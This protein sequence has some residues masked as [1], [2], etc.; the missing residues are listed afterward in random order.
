[1][2]LRICRETA[3]LLLES[4]EVEFGA[5]SPSQGFKG[6]LCPVT[7]QSLR[8]VCLNKNKEL[9]TVC[10]PGTY[11]SQIQSATWPTSYLRCCILQLF[12]SK[13]YFLLSTTPE[14]YCFDTL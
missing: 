5:S 11:F 1:M 10:C 9:R 4:R 13:C 3:V 7:G 6:A 8:T 2:A 14:L 12:L